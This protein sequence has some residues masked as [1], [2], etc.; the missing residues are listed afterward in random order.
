MKMLFA[1]AMLAL[2]AACGQ[3]KASDVAA[4]ASV[5]EARTQNAALMASGTFEGR[6]DHVTTG[7][8]SIRKDGDN[9][10]VVLEEDFSLDG[11]PAPTL[12]F[13]DGEFDAATEFSSLKSNTGYQTYELPASIDPAS[14]SEFYVYCADFSVPLGVAALTFSAT[15]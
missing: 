13:G 1:F 11:A 7:G 9:Y 8:V 6:S 14:Y 4:A 12:G 2:A 10:F 5:D 15:E 3:E